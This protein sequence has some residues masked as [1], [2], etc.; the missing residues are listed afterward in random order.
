MYPHISTALVHVS[1]FVEIT[2][3]VEN[4]KEDVSFW[5]HR[6]IFMKDY[7]GTLSIGALALRVITLLRQNKVDF[8]QD[9]AERD[10]FAEIT[11]QV[12][13]IYKQND[14][15]RK[16]LSKLTFVILRELWNDYIYCCISTQDDGYRHT[17]W[18]NCEL[19]G[20]NFEEK[21]YPA[22][23]P[24]RQP[25]VIK[26]AIQPVLASISSFTDLLPIIEKAK[27]EIS[28]CGCRYI[29]M[30]DDEGTLPIQMLASRS[31]EIAKDTLN[32]SH[33]ADDPEVVAAMDAVYLLS[34]ERKKC[35]Y[36]HSLLDKR[37]VE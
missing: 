10:G 13:A 5:G 30:K 14:A 19:D 11:P 20:F 32:L 35:V 25:Q 28:L 9:K 36:P 17:W 27:P 34:D 31:M 21:H 37:H 18:L 3:L 23:S 15:R 7:D 16:N 2:S 1:S 6:Y 29:Y 24:G 4:A 22:L 12:S 26:E 33:D 8:T